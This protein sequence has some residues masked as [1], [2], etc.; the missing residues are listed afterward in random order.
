MVKIMDAAV[1]TGIPLLAV[2]LVLAIIAV[3]ACLAWN[4]GTIIYVA[5]R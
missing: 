1:D 2:I 3:D 5:T 4:L